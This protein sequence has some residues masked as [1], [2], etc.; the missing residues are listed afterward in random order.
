[1]VLLKQTSGMSG[2]RISRSA[3]GAPYARTTA[4][5]VMPGVSFLM[6]M[7]DPGR[8]D[9]MKTVWPAYPIFTTISALRWL[10]G[11]VSTRLD[12]GCSA[13]PG[14]QPHRPAR[15]R[16]KGRGHRVPLQA[17]HMASQSTTMLGETDQKPVSVDGPQ[18][19]NAPNDRTALLRPAS[20]TPA[21]RGRAA[22][23]RRPGQDRQAAVDAIRNPSR[24]YGG[25]R[26]IR[27]SRYIGTVR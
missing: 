12:S 22:Y 26:R 25:M 4:T 24:G 11:T 16:E 21:R 1:M 3:P 13:L 23:R 9:G 19:V 2:A 8:T 5:A 10:C 27:Q 7:R 14:Q 17:L 15:Q 20:F 18:H 6:I